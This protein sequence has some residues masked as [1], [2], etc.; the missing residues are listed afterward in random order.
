MQVTSC[1]EKKIRCVRETNSKCKH[2]EKAGLAFEFLAV[3]KK[4]G[5]KFT[6]S[7][8]KS[9]PF[10]AQQA[11]TL[12]SLERYKASSCSECQRIESPLRDALCCHKC[13]LSLRSFETPPS[14]AGQSLPGMTATETPP[15][16]GRQSSSGPI[17]IKTATLNCA[18]GRIVDAETASQ[19][20]DFAACIR[21]HTPAPVPHTI[22][23]LELPIHFSEFKAAVILKI[24]LPVLISRGPHTTS[25]LSITNYLTAFGWSSSSSNSIQTECRDLLGN[26]ARIAKDLVPMVRDKALKN[27]L[28]LLSRLGQ[29]VLIKR[30]IRV[31]LCGL[32]K[33][34]AVVRYEG[35]VQMINVDNVVR[36]LFTD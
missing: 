33:K 36:T 10:E 32:G 23:T 2:C 24:H 7:K 28:V 12:V 16:S 6:K 20:N 25:L 9:N 26:L 1:Y 11:S 27:F 29:Q 21:A 4:R 14:T 30:G 34:K 31:E 17:G 15:I 8:E 35:N 22:C 5:R 13:V 19:T 3:P 18:R